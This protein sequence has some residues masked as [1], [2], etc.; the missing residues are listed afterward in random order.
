MEM[1]AAVSF[2]LTDSH[3]SKGQWVAV[4]VSDDALA[5]PLMDTPCQIPP[6]FQHTR[7][8]RRS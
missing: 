7:G 5:Q 1:P 4:K 3:T 8:Q 6:G 2:G